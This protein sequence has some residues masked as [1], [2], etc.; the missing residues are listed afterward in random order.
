MNGELL[1]LVDSIHR[2]K[3]IDQAALFEGIE[4]A[5]TSALHK[6]LGRKKSLQVK[7]NRKTGQIDIRDETGP[8]DLSVA[9]RIAAQTAKQVIIQKI[10]EAES[11]AIYAN[12]ESK[13]H[14]I[15]SGT[16]LRF[17]R[18]LIIVNVAKSEAI[19]PRTEQ[20]PGEAYRIGE[21]IRSLLLSVK[22]EGA[23]V[24]ITL[25]RTHPDFVRKLFELEVP[26]IAD[27]TVSIKNIVREAGF[28]T[29]IAVASNNPKVD[30]VGA[31][32]GVRGNRIKNI[33]EE[34]NGERL[35]IIKWDDDDALLIKNA[36]KPAT[37]Q[38]IEMDTENK[39]ARIFVMPDQLALSIGKK[40]QNIRLA[41]KLT[42]WIIDV[43]STEE[44]VAGEDEVET[45]PESAKKEPEQ[46][47][48]ETVKEKKTEEVSEEP[49]KEEPDTATASEDAADT[50]KPS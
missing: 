19:I 12:L 28:R 50:G 16:V 3:K 30:P 18:G 2:D 17:E 15:I 13:I 29:K 22:K 41:S 45:E 1:R 4:M 48:Q 5:L 27:K 24:R 23:R 25:S 43:V 7:I 49:E 10:K 42:N 14:D 6:H 26:E 9:G 8:I 31:C 36:M 47:K 20:A 40:G 35:D 32:V 44:A 38:A 11:D 39:K 46:E 21:R 37:V 34:L 33:V